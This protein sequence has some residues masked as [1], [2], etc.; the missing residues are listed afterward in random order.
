MA[1]LYLVKHNLN[2]PSYA[3]IKVGNE[4]VCTWNSAHNHFRKFIKHDGIYLNNDHQKEYSCVYFMGEYEPYSIAKLYRKNSYPKAVHYCLSPA[5]LL[6]EIPTGGLNTDPYVFGHRFLNI[7]CGAKNRRYN[8]GDVI[9]F[10]DFGKF[11]YFKFDTV[12]IVKDIISSSLYSRGQYFWAGR[13]AGAIK[14]SQLYE[15]QM[16]CDGTEIYSFVPCYIPTS[17]EIRNVEQENLAAIQNFVLPSIDVSTF[18]FDKSIEKYRNV[19]I[20]STKWE[21][22]YWQRI[23]DEV[24]KAKLFKCIRLAEIQ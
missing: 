21:L 2:E 18:G 24:D 23:L 7:C 4:K 19:A 6:G 14:H 9:L 13:N 8:K 20:N 17:Q 10:G 11:P 1:N 12:F 5:N 15:A 22:V 16:Y 3:C